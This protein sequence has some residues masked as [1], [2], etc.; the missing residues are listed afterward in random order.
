VALLIAGWDL[1]HPLS[2][3]ALGGGH[4]PPGSAAAARLHRLIGPLGVIGLGLLVLARVERSRALA[5]FSVLY[6]VAVA[7]ATPTGIH[8][9]RLF[10]PGILVPGLFLLAGSALFAVLE[11]PATA[12]AP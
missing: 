2:W 7:A 12:G 3:V 11:R 4:L 10:L 8:G 6:L 1:E 9:G 5:A